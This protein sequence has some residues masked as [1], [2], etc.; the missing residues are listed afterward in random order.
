MSLLVGLIGPAVLPA[1]TPS[2]A[3]QAPAGHAHPVYGGRFVFAG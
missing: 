3:L 1:C 2:N